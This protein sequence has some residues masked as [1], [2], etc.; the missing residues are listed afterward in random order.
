MEEYG[1]VLCLH[2]EH[3]DPSLWTILHAEHKFINIYLLKLAAD[4]PYLKIVLEHITTARAVAVVRETPNLYATITAHHLHCTIDAVL[5]GGLK[6]RNY[7]MPVP[8]E[9]W[10]RLCLQ[11]AAF[12][13]Q[14][15]FMLGSDSAYHQVT[16]KLGWRTDPFDPTGLAPTACGCAGVFSAPFLPHYLTELWDKN[17]R[18]IKTLIEFSSENARAVYD[19]PTSDK[20]IRLRREAWTVPSVV[21]DGLAFRG[22]EQLNWV[23]EQV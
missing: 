16:D 4:F 11:S 15:K 6:P 2:G 14:G 9:N 1:C 17:E 5:A 7:C 12:A 21:D 10:D 18:P 3:H 19:L 8:K 20:M 13:P 23:A 22:G